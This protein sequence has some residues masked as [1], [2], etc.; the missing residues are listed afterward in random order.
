MS[1]SISTSI[2]NWDFENL[3]T[4]ERYISVH[5]HIHQKRKYHAVQIR[6]QVSEANGA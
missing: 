2:C 6:G 4:K 5:N 3:R 1:S